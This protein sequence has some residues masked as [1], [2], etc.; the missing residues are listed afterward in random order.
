MRDITVYILNGM[1]QKRTDDAREKQPF[2]KEKSL[3]VQKVMDFTCREGL[4][5][6]RSE[7]HTR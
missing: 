2:T 6:P 4:A 3:R 7:V 1:I 5:G